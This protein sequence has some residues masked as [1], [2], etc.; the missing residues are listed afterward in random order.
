[1]FANHETPSFWR[2]NIA[3]RGI[4]NPLAAIQSAA[5]MLDWLAE[6]HGVPACAE[7]GRGI[8]AAVAAVLAEGHPRPV[9]LGG[10]DGTEAVTHAVVDSL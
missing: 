6:R 2:L 10:A 1:M 9:D 4:A 7:A 8:D 3:G 5:L